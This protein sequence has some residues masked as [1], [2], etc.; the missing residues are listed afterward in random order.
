MPRAGTVDTLFFLMN[1]HS[2]PLDLLVNLD[3]GLPSLEFDKLDSEAARLI[4][5][6]KSSKSTSPGGSKPDLKASITN[7]ES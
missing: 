7:C 5:C 6:V 1:G 2:L 3:S 4:G